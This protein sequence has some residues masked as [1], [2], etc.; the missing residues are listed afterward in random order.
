MKKWLVRARILC[1]IVSSID[2]C[3]YPVP[4]DQG[5]EGGPFG[6]VNGTA[7]KT[8]P[9]RLCCA[10][11]LYSHSHFSYSPSTRNLS[12]HSISIFSGNKFNLPHALLAK[13]HERMVRFALS[14]GTWMVDIIEV[15]K[16]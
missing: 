3:H 4:E 6:F 12:R 8:T 1:H 11:L 5:N 16:S 7:P 9:V 15:I 10:I 13:T 2:P 14:F